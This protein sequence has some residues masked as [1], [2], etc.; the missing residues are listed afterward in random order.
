MADANIQ[1]W[2]ERLGA[3]K[4]TR[5]GQEGCLTEWGRWKRAGA[6]HTSHGEAGAI[7]ET[8]RE[9]TLG[10]PK[11]AKG[12]GCKDHTVRVRGRTQFQNYKPETGVHWMSRR[13][14]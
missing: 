4:R 10:G 12:L 6:E 1:F 5:L 7:Q 2:P 11:S 8:S 13:D 14:C 3:E 9:C